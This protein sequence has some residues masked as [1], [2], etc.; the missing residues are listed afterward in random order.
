MQKSGH[1]YRLLMVLEAIQTFQIQRSRSGGFEDIVV[2]MHGSA[3]ESMLMLLR[4]S[5]GRYRDAG[6]Y[7]ANWRVVEGDTVR[8]LKEPRLTPCEAR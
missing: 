1:E 6:C 5:R 4:Y 3:T 8:D 2:A 7:D